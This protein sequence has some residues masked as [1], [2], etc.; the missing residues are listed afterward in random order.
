[1]TIQGLRSRWTRY[2]STLSP[3]ERSELRAYIRHARNDAARV[4]GQP[5]WFMAPQ[6]LNGAWRRGHGDPGFLGDI[7]WAQYCLFFCIRLQ[8]DI[9][10]GHWNQPAGVFLSNRLLI[11]SERT[12]A[13]HFN[14]Q[15]TFWRCF[16]GFVEQ[17][18]R[19]ILA[20]RKAQIGTS[21]QISVFRRLYA[22]VSAVLKTAS[23]AVCF[24]WNKLGAFEQI[25]KVADAFAFIGQTIDDLQDIESDS[26]SGV[27]T[28][29][30]RAILMRAGMRLKKNGNHLERTVFQAAFKADGL[31]YLIS[32][33]QREL[34]Q[35][36][37]DIV[38]LNITPLERYA[39]R[40]EK[41]LT[42]ISHHHHNLRFAYLVGGRKNT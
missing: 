32:L 2:V 15:D 20:V 24:K 4:R 25:D 42:I 8:D 18:S 37:P 33:L 28:F 22:E 11:E 23:A 10:D 30:S 41:Y 21:T 19:S 9:L 29:A 1:M 5:Y 38:S 6:W 27:V 13:R 14:G 17:T 7:L 26:G 31:D 3:V 12:L 16:F 36:Q 40:Y 34:K 39:S 35:I